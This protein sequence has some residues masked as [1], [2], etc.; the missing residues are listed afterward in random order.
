MKTALKAGF[1]KPKDLA[2]ERSFAEVA[3]EPG[4]RH[5]V[6][7]SAL[8]AEHDLEVRERRLERALEALNR[9]RGR[10]PKEKLSEKALVERATRILVESKVA[11]YFSYTAERGFFSFWLRR[12]LYRQE[13][14]EDGFFVL[15][16]N[17][18]EMRP[19]EILAS[20]VQLQ[21][22]ERAFRVVKSLLKLRP[23][24][25]WRQRRVETHN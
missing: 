3:I 4:H 13:R 10:A 12:D 8:R 9:L 15:K 22:V 18:L 25:H 20:Y 23:I 17:H 24:Y 1:R 7:Y 14:R 11:K 16:T 19:E 21:E 2:A 6:V 5:L